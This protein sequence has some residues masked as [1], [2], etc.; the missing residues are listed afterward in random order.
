MHNY[1]IPVDLVANTTIAA[2]AKHGKAQTPQINVYN[3]ASGLR[4]PLTFFDAFEY[5]FEYFEDKPLIESAKLKKVKFFDDFE[6][7]SK[8]IKEEMF[9]NHGIARN[10][11]GEDRKKVRQ[12]NA[13]AEYA[14]QLCKLYEFATFF[15]ARYVMI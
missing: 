2:T 6:E 10:G 11:V 13:K 8:F 1:Q 15:D 5:L 3:V 7:F 9:R 14:Q 4:N 12:C